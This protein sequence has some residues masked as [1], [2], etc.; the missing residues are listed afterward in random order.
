M[1]SVSLCFSLSHVQQL[2]PNK[3]IKK[4]QFP[5]Y[6]PFDV[7]KLQWRWWNKVNP[8][9]SNFERTIIL[10][11]DFLENLNGQ[12]VFPERKDQFQNKKKYIYIYIQTLAPKWFVQVVPP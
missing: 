6:R 9:I 2:G 3:R 10:F 1:H 12:I 7:F 11:R 8:E 4:K 5:F